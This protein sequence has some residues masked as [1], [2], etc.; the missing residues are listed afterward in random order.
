[1]RIGLM[2]FALA[3]FCHAQIGA[4]QVG[5][6]TDA[7]RSLRPVLG[8]AGNLLLGE[9][10]GED[11]LSSASSGA[12]TLV[13]T[14]SSVLVLNRHGEIAM[15]AGEPRKAFGLL[16]AAGPSELL[17]EWP[18][19]LVRAAFLSGEKETLTTWLRLLF[20]N[21]GRYW[22]QC[23]VTGPGFFRQAIRWATG[24]LPASG[25]QPLQEF[26]TSRTQ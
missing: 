11:C 18:E 19:P 22:L 2:V 1:M 7:N 10:L 25:F 12:F 4:P 20:G 3:S 9:S 14:S 15:T 26:L 6:I 21:P 23:D 17:D 5:L 8:L 24:V 16:T 13:K